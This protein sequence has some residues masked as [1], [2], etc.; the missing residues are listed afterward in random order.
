MK[1]LLIAAAVAGLVGTANAQSAFEGAF[2]QLGIG[3]QSSKPKSVENINWSTGS[4]FAST[5]GAG[6]NFSL[7]NEFLLGV[8]AEYSFLP[9]SSAN[10][11]YDGGAGTFKNKNT[12]NIFVSPGFALS[13]DSLAYAKVGYTGTSYEFTEGGASDTYNLNGYSFGLGYKQI[14]NGGVYGFAEGNYLTYNQKTL[15]SGNVRLS[16]NSMNFLVGVGYKF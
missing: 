1:K 12:Y 14:I 16:G 7:S 6:Y 15:E 11:S 10:Y 3:Y 4:G 9:T 8:G 5:V 13:K 2:G